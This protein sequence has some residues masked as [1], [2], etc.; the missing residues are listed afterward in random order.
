MRRKFEAADFETYIAG[1]SPALPP[2]G[3]AICRRI[4]AALG[5]ARKTRSDRYHGSARIASRKV[6]RTR[7]A[8]SFSEYNV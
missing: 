3:E 5:A 8:E 7:E 1:L 2:G 4:W 6:G